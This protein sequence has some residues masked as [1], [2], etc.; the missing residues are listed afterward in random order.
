MQGA[1]AHWVI[2]ASTRGEACRLAPILRRVC[3]ARGET[4][5]A[6][7]GSIESALDPA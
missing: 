6:V 2:V 7:V 3:L 5:A 1:T 4:G